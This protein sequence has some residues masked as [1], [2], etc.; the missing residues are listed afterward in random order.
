MKTTM[1]LVLPALGVLTLGATDGSVAMPAASLKQDRPIVQVY[2]HGRPHRPRVR[3]YPD[4]YADPHPYP[5]DYVPDY[6]Y[7]Y[8]PVRGFGDY[9]NVYRGNMRGCSVDLGYGRYE[10]CDK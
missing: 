8:P 10:S 1:L 7:H 5:Y 6:S 4:G 2:H 9:S 3:V